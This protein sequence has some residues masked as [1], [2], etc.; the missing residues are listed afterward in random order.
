MQNCFEARGR[1]AIVT[2]LLAAIPQ[3]DDLLNLSCFAQ[4]A[5]AAAIF[6]AD[7]YTGSPITPSISPSST[8]RLTCTWDSW[9]SASAASI[10]APEAY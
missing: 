6:A 8:T 7:A 3:I 1:L 4:Y 10:A 2:S 9:V 5:R